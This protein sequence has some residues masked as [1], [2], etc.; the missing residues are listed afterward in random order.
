MYFRGA[1]NEASPLTV[2]AMRVILQSRV[3]ERLDPEDQVRLAHLASRCT[4]QGLRALASLLERMDGK[5][6]NDLD[7]LAS[8]NVRPRLGTEAQWRFPSDVIRELAEP[9]SV[10]QSI[11][12]SCPSAVA[13]HAL[14]TRYPQEL[15]RLYRGLAQSGQVTMW[16]GATLQAKVAGVAKNRRDD[17]SCSERTF[18]ISC[19]KYATGDQSPPFAHE[20][21]LYPAQ[22]ERLYS[23]LFPHPYKALD[24][25]P[26]AL[27]TVFS[28]H[29]EA[30]SGAP[31]FLIMRSSDPEFRHIVELLGEHDDRIEYW[32]PNRY[33]HLKAGA[34]LAGRG[35]RKERDDEAVFSFAQEDFC[36]Q[37]LGVAAPAFFVDKFFPPPAPWFFTLPSLFPTAERPA[38]PNEL[39]LW[40]ERE[41]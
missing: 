35:A 33:V 14:S 2:P 38:S 31:I 25:E 20:T 40:T 18:Q 22:I 11:A 12:F 21:G 16:G 26:T 7:G 6:L 10:H 13:E 8:A 3:L 29:P 5:L 28:N 36:K 15:A 30:V 27:W 1:L 17:R 32:D 23:Q 41:K 19:Y 34:L 4:G 9:K 37:V 24:L 39:F